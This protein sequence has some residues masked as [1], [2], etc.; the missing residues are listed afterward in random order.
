MEQGLFAVSGIAFYFQVQAEIP[1]ITEE[2][3]V[4]GIWTSGT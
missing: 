1:V 4:K 2:E 3:R